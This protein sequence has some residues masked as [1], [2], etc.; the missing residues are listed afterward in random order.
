MLLFSQPTF[1]CPKSTMEPTEK[2]VKYV[3]TKTLATSASGVYVLKRIYI[4][5]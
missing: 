5:F 4:L 1:A 3:K 2:C